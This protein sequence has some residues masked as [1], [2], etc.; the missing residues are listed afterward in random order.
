MFSG[1]P[2]AICLEQT[3]ILHSILFIT[4]FVNM[5]LNIFYNDVL[6]AQNWRFLGGSLSAVPFSSKR[7]EPLLGGA[8]RG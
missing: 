2:R 3:S 4:I 6:F 1:K 8:T 5:S 7:L